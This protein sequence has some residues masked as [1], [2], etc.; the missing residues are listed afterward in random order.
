[1]SPM[2]CELKDGL[3]SGLN[4]TVRIVFQNPC[5]MHELPVVEMRSMMVFVNEV[6]WWWRTR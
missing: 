2:T 3:P 6:Y 1:M 4:E 5:S